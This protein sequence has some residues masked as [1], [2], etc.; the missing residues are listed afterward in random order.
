MNR[1]PIKKS[2]IFKFFKKIHRKSILSEKVLL[3]KSEGRIISKNITSKIKIPPFNNSAVDGYALHKDNI[4]DNKRLY[5]KYRISAGQSDDILLKKNEVARIFTGAK[6]PL[7]SITVVMQENSILDKNNYLKILKNPKYGDN[8][9]KAGED[10]TKNKLIFSAGK[11]INSQNLNLFAAIGI[12]DIFVKKKIKI[13]YFTSG[14]ELKEPSSLLK[15]SEIYNSNRYLLLSLLSKKFIASKYLGILKDD[16]KLIK[17]LILK[18]T[19]KHDVIITTG[20]ASVGEEDHIISVIKKLG[21]IFFWKTAIKPGRPLCVGKINETII[22]SLPGNPVSVYL[23]YVM[24]IYPF[25]KFLCGA[26][27]SS[28]KSIKVKVNF[29]MRKKTERLEWIRVKISEKSN[30][31]I[32]VDKYPKQGSGMISSIVYSDGIIEVPEN[33]NLIKKGDIFDFYFFNQLLN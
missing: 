29:S 13:G 25:L 9:R 32:Y 12:S 10:I 17:K 14:N 23:L 15:K 11:K 27:L 1:F 30:D 18:Q 3:S 4:K 20:G 28:P 24:I 22:I 31:Q 33:I 8:C 7:N 5:C 2:E 19:K 21:K 6:M 16:Y 26:P